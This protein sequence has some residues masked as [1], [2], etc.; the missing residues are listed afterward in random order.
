MSD[1]TN[2]AKKALKALDE[3]FNKEPVTA[4]FDDRDDSSQDGEFYVSYGTEKISVPIEPGMTVAKAFKMYAAEL[5]FDPD[6]LVTYRSGGQK[7]SGTAKPEVGKIY[8]A[9]VQHEQKG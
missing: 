8:S 6:R 1:S 4:D 7:V 2:K 5:S 3:L 9:S